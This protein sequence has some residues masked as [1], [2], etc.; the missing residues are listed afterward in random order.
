ME[1]SMKSL[2]ISF[3]KA[4]ARAGVLNLDG[5]LISAVLDGHARR[6]GALVE[7]GADVHAEG[8]MALRMAVLG[9]Q[10][11]TIAAFRD[12]GVNVPDAAQ[13][14]R[15]WAARNRAANELFLARLNAGPNV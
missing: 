8:D 14:R 6:A 5:A 2:L 12:A 15:D 10:T 3:Y 11:K 1:T 9:E 7:A 13:V 4:C